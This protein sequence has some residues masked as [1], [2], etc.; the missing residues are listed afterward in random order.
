MWKKRAME[1]IKSDSGM[2]LHSKRGINTSR[3]KV[4]QFLRY[5][6]ECVSEDFERWGETYWRRTHQLPGVLVCTDHKGGLANSVVPYR[7]IA[8]VDFIDA[9]E[10]H[11]HLN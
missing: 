5:C 4:P 8:L 3:V 1:A 10:A 2:G 7:P 6:P 11:S 9:S